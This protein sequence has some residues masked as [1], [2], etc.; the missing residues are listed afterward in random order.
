MKVCFINTNIAWGGGEKWHYEQAKV[1]RHAGF[2]I[3]FITHP[4]S[5]LSQ[6]ISNTSFSQKHFKVNKGSHLN[7]LLKKRISSY[8]SEQNFDAVILNLPQDVKTFSPLA[9][10]KVKK[11]IYRRGMDH[12]IKG[13]RLNKKIYPNYLTNIIANSENVK[14]SISK[15]I[16]ELES[17]VKVIYNSISLD[18]IPLL[19]KTDSKLILGNLGRL[20][21]QK[22]QKL[23]IPLAQELIK[24]EIDFKILIAGTGPLKEELS[25]LISEN[26]L[27][28]Y[29]KL[30]G[31]IDSE[32]FFKQIDYFVFPSQF[33][34][35]SNAL[36]EAQ[37]YRKPSFAYNIS[38]NSEIIE[39]KK[40]GFLFKYGDTQKM[41]QTIIELT[42]D[43]QR[44]IS[45]QESCII[46]LKE[47][48]DKN[49]T[50]QQLIEL[51]NE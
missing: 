4:K 21:E 1:L 20:V 22:S 29:I 19:K 39:D 16:P 41:A 27:E 50:N 3:S 51:L 6:K 35:L 25:T 45:I 28:G 32:K 12:P 23:L 2:D 42:K 38:S 9:Y 26:N 13:S 14:K 40:N 34:G 24:K 18:E 11:V 31:H 49:I 5:K 7:F 48:F 33:E 46:N 10:N 30:L 17:K 15:F 8:L 36:L 43:S 47:K 37:L 44:L